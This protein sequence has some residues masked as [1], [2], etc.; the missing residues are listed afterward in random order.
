MLAVV[1]SVF[2]SVFLLAFQSASR[3]APRDAVVLAMLACAMV[4][5]GGLVLARRKPRAP[6]SRRATWLTIAVFA[7]TTIGGN[8]GVAGAL[9]RLGPGITGT[10]LQTQVFLVAVGGR[11]FLGEKVGPSFL[12]GAGLAFAGFVVLGLADPGQGRVDPAGVGFALLASACFGGMLLWTRAVIAKIEPVTVNVVRLVFA[13][14]VM[15]LLPGRLGAALSLPS[16]VWLAIAIA[17]ACGPFLS[18]LALLFAAAHLSAS[19]TKLITLISPVLAFGLE[20]AVLGTPP[21]AHELAAGALILGGVLLPV[22]LEARA[23]RA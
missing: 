15:V 14:A 10:I 13:V 23:R 8:I 12:A 19:R 7:A 4:L 20:W 6:A 9:E 17:A 5:N 16:H 22:A 1:S 21:A 11:L 2:A 18:R 3:A